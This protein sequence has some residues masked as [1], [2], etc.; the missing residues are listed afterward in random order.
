MENILVDESYS[1]SLRAFERQVSKRD[2]GQ[3]SVGYF[4]Q[5]RMSNLSAYNQNHQTT[6]QPV[7]EGNLS[8]R[9][10][11]Q[12]S[13]VLNTVGKNPSSKTNMLINSQEFG[14]FSKRRNIQDG[15]KTTQSQA[16]KPI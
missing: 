6:N 7:K 12:Q 8:S 14:A 10:A 13:N 5:S 9:V 11:Y 1:F 15:V 3:N 16:K 4:E 2:L